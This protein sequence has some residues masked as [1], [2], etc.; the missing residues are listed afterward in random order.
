MDDEFRD[1]IQGSKSSNTLYSEKTTCN[2][3]KRYLTS[4]NEIREP[5]MI[6]PDELCVKML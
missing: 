5:N 6:P 4:I 2:V 3:F 1:F